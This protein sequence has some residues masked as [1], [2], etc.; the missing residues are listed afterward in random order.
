M[1]E[2]MNPWKAWWKWRCWRGRRVYVR[3]F[4]DVVRAMHDDPNRRMEI[5]NW[6]GDARGLCEVIGMIDD[7]RTRKLLK[8]NT[9]ILNDISDLGDQRVMKPKGVGVERERLLNGVCRRQTTLQKLCFRTESIGGL[10]IRDV[11]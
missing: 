6:Y 9:F 11:K 8:S 3:C 5:S 10:S 2:V 4:G 7:Q 1:H